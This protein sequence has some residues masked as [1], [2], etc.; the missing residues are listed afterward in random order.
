[1]GKQPTLHPS[2]VFDG[3][4]YTQKENGYYYNCTTRKHLHQAVWIY[5]NGPIPPGH[6]IHHIDFD[7]ENNDISNLACLTKEEHHRL[8]A[9]AL[10]DEQRKWKRD[11][12]NSNARP[13]A[14]NWHK[15]KEG[16]EWHKQHAIQMA[17]EGKSGF[18]KRV[19]ITCTE[20][21]KEY[22]G[23]MH[24]KSG[25][26][27]CSNA[28]KSRYR[29]RSGVDNNERFCVICGKKYSTSKFSDS[30]TCSVSCANRLRSVIKRRA[31]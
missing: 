27:F 17:K 22:M 14:I 16:L 15:S 5:H 21:G 9:E 30:V 25:N 18:T 4:H 13:A 24:S 8:H 23:V 10:T 1:M 7:K 26:H 11:N 12:L 3:R 29:R 6:E 2:I 31:C 19:Q 28:C 20:C